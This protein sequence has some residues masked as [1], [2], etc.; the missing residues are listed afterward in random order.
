MVLDLCE[1]WSLVGVWFLH[2]DFWNLLMCMKREFLIV[3]SAPKKWRKDDLYCLCEGLL[4]LQGGHV[5]AFCGAYYGSMVCSKLHEDGDGD[6]GKNKSAERWAFLVKKE[7]WKS[8]LKMADNSKKKKR[9]SKKTPS[10]F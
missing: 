3:F 9:K 8:E 5:V 1:W 7:Q 6:E 10:L 2:G 4:L